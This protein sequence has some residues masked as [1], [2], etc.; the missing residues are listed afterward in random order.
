[1]TPDF[2]KSVVEF[3][4]FGLVV[5]LVLYVLF[6]MAPAFLEALDKSQSKFHI[7]L[8]ESRVRFQEQL[9]KLDERQDQRHQTMLGEMRATRELIE[10]LSRSTARDNGVKH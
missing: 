5:V 10:T 6:R 3:G 8:S 4:S 1:M 2:V 9:T 7:E